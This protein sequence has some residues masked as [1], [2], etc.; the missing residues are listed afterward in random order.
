MECQEVNVWAG[1]ISHRVHPLEAAIDPLHVEQV[2]TY[3]TAS[4]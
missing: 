1:N 4:N 2:F 3:S